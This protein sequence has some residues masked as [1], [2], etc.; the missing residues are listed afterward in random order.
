MPSRRELVRRVVVGVAVTTA[1]AA[2]ALAWS[3]TLLGEYSVMDMGGGAHGAPTGHAGSTAEA[4]P[5][6]AA[7]SG[8]AGA[9]AE[10]SVTVAHRRPRP[11]RRRARRARRPAGDDRRA[12]RAPRSTATP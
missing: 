3:S 5:A 11:P 6:P 10:V 2:G 1:L 7:A 9:A 8:T 12:R 4:G